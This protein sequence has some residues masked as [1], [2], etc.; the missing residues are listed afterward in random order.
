MTFLSPTVAIVAAAI[1]LPTLLILY[2][3]KLRRRDM[4]ISTTLLWRKAVQDLQANAPFQ[5]L[6]RNILLLLQLLVLGA[7][8]FALAQPQ[9]SGEAKRGQKH[10]IL[11]DRSA[12]MLTRDETD[13]RGREVT[14][15]DAAKE[16]AGEL[17]ESLR[18]AG[19]LQR[20]S[21]DEAMV[22]LFDTTATVRQNFTGDKGILKSALDSINATESPTLIKE[23]MRLAKAHAP[24]RIV[25][26]QGLD[27]GEPITIHIFSDGNLPD[28][29]EAKADPTDEVLFHRFGKAE[30]GNIA[31]TG[32]RSDRSFEDPSQLSVYVSLQNNETTQRSVD[33]ELVIDG[34]VSGIRNSLVPAASSTLLSGV[35]AARERR[36]QADIA[37][38]TSETGTATDAAL[39]E[40]ETKIEPGIGGVVFQISRSE[41]AVI[42]IN[43][44]SPGTGELLA[45]ALRIDNQAWLIV[46]P[47]RKLAVA[48]ITNR[49]ISPVADVLEGLPLARLVTMAPADFDRFR[50]DNRLGEFD[51]FVFDGWLPEAAPESVGLP[52]GRSIVLG[53]VPGARSGITDKGAGPATG[54]VDWSRDHPVL[55]YAPLDTLVIIESRQVELEQGGPTVAIARADTGPA[56]LELTTADTHAIIVPFD[57]L[58]TNWPFNLSFVIFTA[59]AINYLG[60]DLGLSGGSRQLRPGSVLSDRLPL[61]A[62]DVRLRTPAGEEQTLTPAA[63]GRIVFGPVT[64]TGLFTV[65]WK[66]PEGPSDVV[67]GG[68]VRRAYASNLSDPAESMVGSSERVD[69]AN[70]RVS[71][72][73]G[74]AAA[75]VQRLWPWF[76]LG[77]LA[78]MMLEWF[79]YNRKVH[80]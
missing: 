76:L 73:Q 8:I 48:L 10:V 34:V 32:V 14:R 16:S 28:A 69:L 30:T 52:P 64:E 43:L 44:R 18:E 55:R 50:A 11:I 75:A 45:D 3:L 54:I 38:A 49:G 26:G 17:V 15:L 57:T 27:F 65:S 53:A 42:Q 56:I 12:S 37:A 29:S 23:A 79:I 35:A 70:D 24:Q 66:G 22:V 78:V 77:A 72:R 25:E 58:Q 46:P 51:V 68:R 13:S 2:F 31:I 62:T 71:A 19:L 41:G 33:I 36:D 60:D 9:I 63:D 67:S 40:P 1:A 21:A 39:P 59:T 5:K 6:R 7:A 61:N 74:G 47:A 20:D 4:E 80:V